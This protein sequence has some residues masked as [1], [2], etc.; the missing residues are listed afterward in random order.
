MSGMLLPIALMLQGAPAAEPPAVQVEQVAP[1]QKAS[2]AVSAPNI[3]TSPVR[4]PADVPQLPQT[5]EAPRESA[6]GEAVLSSGEDSKKNLAAEV[7]RAV[8]FIRQRGQQPTPE[9][10]AREIGPDALA[11]YLNQ[12]PSHVGIFSAPENSH[13][14]PSAD[15]DL[16]D[17]VQVVLPVSP[18]N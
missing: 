5:L 18:G 7:A 13:P 17:G 11:T 6:R 4:D 10:L 14:N 16:P 12:D 9:T 3:T 1:D 2:S 8:E 15:P